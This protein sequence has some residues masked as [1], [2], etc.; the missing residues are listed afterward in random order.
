MSRRSQI[1]ILLTAGLVALA[2]NATAQP[3]RVRTGSYNRGAYNNRWYNPAARTV[4]ALRLAVPYG[5]YG[6][7]SST[8]MESAQRG[9][10]SVLR[11]QGQYQ[12]DASKA[13]VNYEQARQQ[14]IENKQK[15]TETYWKRKREGEAERAKDYEEKRAVRDRYRKSQDRLQTSQTSQPNRMTHA[16]FDSNTGKIDWPEP[17]K[18]DAFAV[19]RQQLENEFALR[20]QTQITPQLAEDIRDSTNQLRDVLKRNIRKMSPSDYISARQFIDRLAQES[21]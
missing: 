14:Y 5:Y 19:H 10:A 17:L 12:L 3:T 1:G 7:F 2:M 20:A 6:N 13:A 11:A 18:S 21:G 4:G 15:W 8:P 16:E 9:Y